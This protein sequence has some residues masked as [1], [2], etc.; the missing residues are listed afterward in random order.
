MKNI[1]N[2][3]T[4]R[5]ER[6]FTLIEL[7]VV[8]AIIAVLIAF[9]VTNYLGARQRAK[10]VKKKSELQEL[11]TAL[12]LYYNDF[13]IYPPDATTNDLDGCGNATPPIASCNSGEFAAGTNVYMKLLP[14][15]AS[16]VWHYQPV[17]VA[18]DDFC[19][20]ATLDN[21]SDT[22]ITASQAKC[23]DSCKSANPALT[24]SDYTLCA[25]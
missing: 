14:Q 16:Y 17:G 22:D 18:R 8:I 11:K 9:A 19:L 5:F 4:S 13:N 21:A 20:W 24:T 15:A 7:L 6:G 25:D 1:R 3:I 2:R 10:D 23:A 12:R